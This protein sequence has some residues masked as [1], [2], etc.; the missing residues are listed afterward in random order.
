MLTRTQCEHCRHIARDAFLEAHGDRRQA[1][2]IARRNLRK[3]PGSIVGM[4][5]LSVAA[6][7]IVWLIT[8]WIESNFAIPPDRYVP[9]ELGFAGLTESDIEV[10]PADDDGGDE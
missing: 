3:D 5:L 9:G 2:R 7:L 8:K 10:L 6:R 1:I 4:I